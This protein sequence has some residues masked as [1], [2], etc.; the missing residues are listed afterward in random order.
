[1]SWSGENALKEGGELLKLAM[2]YD[3]AGKKDAGQQLEAAKAYTLVKRL[4]EEALRGS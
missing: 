4:F 3:K 1:M 2:K